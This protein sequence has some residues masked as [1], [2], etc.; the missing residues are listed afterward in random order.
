MKRFAMLAAAAALL[1]AC[2]G[3]SEEVVDENAENPTGVTETGSNVDNPFGALT[4][5][6]NAGK[7]IQAW[8][9]EIQNM[10]P[11]EPVS[12]NVLIAALPDVPGGWT[13]DEPFG[14]KTSMG[15]FTMSQAS[16][17]YRQDGTDARVE[18]KIADWAY[19]QA[20]Y[21][22]FMALSAFS[23]ESTEGYNKG[24]TIGEDPGHE[25]F[26][27]SS[28]RGTRQVLYRKRFHTQIETSNLPA[29]AMQEWWERMKV[30]ELP[31]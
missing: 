8:Q 21:I 6:M 22:P 13:A 14:E 18:F 24:I 15:A 27:N 5:I 26:K 31:Q 4:G 19:N 30:G 20:I 28:M 10:E 1:T 16:R 3:G 29:E 12:F 7:N 9:E 23:Q 2:G 11:V 17:T 25:E